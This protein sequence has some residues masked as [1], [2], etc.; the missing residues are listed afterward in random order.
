M[1][2]IKKIFLDSFIYFIL[3]FIKK[4]FF[5]HGGSLLLHAGYSL[6]AARGLLS[7]VA[8]LGVWASVVV[9]KRIY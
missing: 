8:S 9:A 6:V 3:L 5:E 1:S 4:T 2:F 7:V